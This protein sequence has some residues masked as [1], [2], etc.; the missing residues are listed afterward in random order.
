MLAR[1]TKEGQRLLDGFLNRGGQ[2]R[3][4]DRP[5]S[6]PRGEIGLIK[7]AA[8]IEPSKLLQAIV[9]AGDRGRS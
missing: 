9:A 8:I 7:V 2:A 3:I 6:Q 4:A 5:F 1:Q